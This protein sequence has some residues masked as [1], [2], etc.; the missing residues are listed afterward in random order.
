MVATC[1]VP[2]QSTGLTGSSGSGSPVSGQDGAP[3]LS[4]FGPRPSSPGTAKAFSSIGGGSPRGARSAARSSTPRFAASSDAWRGRSPPGAA[5]ASRRNSPCSVTRSLNSPSPSICTELHLGPR[6][7]GESFSPR[8][9]ASS[10]PLTSSWFLPSPSVCSSSSSSFATTARQLVHLNVTDHP[11]AAWTA[12]QLFEV[13]PDETAPTY[14][15][16]DR[17]AVY[18]DEFVRRVQAMGIREVLIA[19]RA[20]W[21]KAQASY[22]TSFRTCGA[23][24]G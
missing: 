7:R 10:S 24:W 13:F 11:T 21:Q 5:G 22:C 8:T 6:L 4:S 16:R 20:P 14:L 12:R 3:V 9:S 18:G 2:R 15:V 19:P 1:L 23:H 17:D